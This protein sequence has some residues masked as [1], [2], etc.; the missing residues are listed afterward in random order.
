MIILKN[1]KVLALSLAILCF[2]LSA[3][4]STDYKMAESLVAEGKYE[5]AIAAFNALGD[6]KD[7]K[8]RADIVSYD[9]ARQLLNNGEWESAVTIA[10][11]IDTSD[12]ELCESVEL[13]L[14][15]CDLKKAEELLTAG[16]SKE[17]LDICQ[18]VKSETTN[19]SIIVAADNLKKKCQE[20]LSLGDVSK[21]LKEAQSEYEKKNWKLVV[22]L[23]TQISEIA[24]DTE[25]SATAKTLQENAVAEI[26]SELTEI[27]DTL[28]D[29]I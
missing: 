1:K 10:K 25:V 22:S 4:N 9:W 24:P 23:C 20:V 12:S 16:K 19:S 6:F 7:A 27:M 8:H 5:E 13:L 18:K 17:A 28:E 29:L 2:C 21:L 15:Q 26:E 11:G 14:L 3:C